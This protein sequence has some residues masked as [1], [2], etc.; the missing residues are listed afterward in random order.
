[1]IH[2]IQKTKF[3]LFFNL[4]V[5]LTLSIQGWAQFNLNDARYIG[6]VPKQGA[7]FTGEVIF[8]NYASI[9]KT[10]FL[11]GVRN[12]SIQSAEV[13]E[14]EVEGSRVRSESIT[15][16][17]EAE[18]SHF[19]IF[20]SRQVT[21]ALNVRAADSTNGSATL[22]PETEHRGQRF[23][24]FPSIDSGTIGAWEGLAM[25]N[26]NVID[27]FGDPSVQVT[28]H[29]KT[30][31]GDLLNARDYSLGPA[32]KEI[33][34]LGTDFPETATMSRETYYYEIESS[35]DIGVTF[36]KGNT[37]TADI[38]TAYP[39]VPL[40]LD[41]VIVGLANAQQSFPFQIQ[42]AF[43]DGDVLNL[44]VLPDQNC[45]WELKIYRPDSDPIIGFDPPS[46]Q[47][48]FQPG[49]DR[50]IPVCQGD[51]QPIEKEFDLSELR[52]VFGTL[53]FNGSIEL[54]ILD[55]N[56]QPFTTLLWIAQLGP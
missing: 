38:T 13:A 5:L 18:I 39:I 51:A 15:A 22:L 42:E 9:P 32:E 10:I 11:L 17:F 12:G 33:L 52:N 8:T 54:K 24:I 26:F 36:L 49:I 6:H 25:L 30:R 45:S 7:G 29:L 19:Y 41:G 20:G 2:T 48:V 28:I 55:Y 37:R 21:V 34:V 46:T 40:Q 35:G 56:G 27:F 31:D 23:M 50:L 16:L 47:I 14:V 53:P 43:L 1:M 44:K 3:T 4:L